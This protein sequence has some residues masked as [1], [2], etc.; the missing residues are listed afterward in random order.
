MGGEESGSEK[1]RGEEEMMVL[2]SVEAERGGAAKRGEGGAKRGEGGGREERSSGGEEEL[3]DR[4]WVEREEG[5]DRLSLGPRVQ[6]DGRRRGEFGGR[7]WS[8]SLHPPE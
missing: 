4:W 2:S 8:A 7:R 6:I 1:K 3:R 5:T